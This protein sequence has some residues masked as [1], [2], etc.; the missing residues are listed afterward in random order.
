MVSREL[1]KAALLIEF[2]Q[3]GVDMLKC[4][5]LNPPITEQ[6]L[7]TAW[8]ALL[9]GD[10]FDEL[11]FN[12]IMVNIQTRNAW[13]I[14]VKNISAVSGGGPFMNIDEAAHYLEIYALS[15]GLSDDN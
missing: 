15:T 1:I 8:Q 2:N 7:Q 12:C 9:S 10:E 6:Q 5:N 3:Y 14:P 11:D 13:H 4:L